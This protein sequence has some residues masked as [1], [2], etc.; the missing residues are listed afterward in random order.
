MSSLDASSYD[1]ALKV[2]YLERLRNFYSVY[3]TS[4]V[5]EAENLL[6]KYAGKEEKLF[7]ALVQKYGPE[8]ELKEDTPNGEQEGENGE[9]AER[10]PES[11]LEPLPV[12][13]YE[14]AMQRMQKERL[15]AF[16]SHYDPSKVADVDKL[17][18]KYAGKED[19]L[20]RALT[21]KYGP[22]PQPEQPVDDDGEEE[23]EGEGTAPGREPGSGE[24]AESM[25]EGQGSS[26]NKEILYCGVCGMP[27]EYC[28]YGDLEKCRPWLE[29]NAPWVLEPLDEAM[30][31]MDL[32]NEDGTRSKKKKKRGG[33]GPKKRPEIDS[34]KQTVVV[35]R[36]SRGGKKVVT[37][38]VGLDY[39]PTCGKIKDICKSLGKRFAC[40]TAVKETATGEKEIVIQGDVLYEIVDVL[41][42]MFKIGS[43]K[44][45]LEEESGKKKRK[46]PK[47]P[48]PQPGVHPGGR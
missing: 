39:F 20:F 22:E 10:E 17:I 15:L 16:Y 34:S 14:E 29:D 11:S 4:K 41:E 19:A 23:E 1:A 21:K 37:H 38:V 24:A 2:K 43:D 42:S 18:S 12:E 47:L 31:N 6:T 46:E 26:S 5:D 13:T 36:S 3:E 32:E 7:A 30:S 27:P 45:K 44:I 8:P 35:S 40:S 48:P 9:S 28:E 33:Q 25:A